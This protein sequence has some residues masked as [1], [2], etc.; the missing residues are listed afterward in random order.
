[1]RGGKRISIDDVP[2]E[3]PII[4]YESKKSIIKIKK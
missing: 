4:I 3:K 2:F 1:M